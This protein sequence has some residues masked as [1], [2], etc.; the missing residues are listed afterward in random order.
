MS[1]ADVYRMICRRAAAA[2]M[3]TRINCI[4]CVPLALRSICAMGR[5]EIA[6]QMANH[7]STCTSLDEVERILIWARL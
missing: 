2:E 6:R 1:Q 4:R 7:E 5:L 3:E